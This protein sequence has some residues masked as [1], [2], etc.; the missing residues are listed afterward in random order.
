VQEDTIIVNQTITHSGFVGEQIL[1]TQPGTFLSCAGGSIGWAL[2]AAL[3]AKLAAK[4]RTV[5]SLMGDGAYVWGCPVATFWSAATYKAPFLSIIFNNQAYA[6]IK[7]IVQRAYGVEKLSAEIGREAGVDINPP[8]DYAAVARACGA[9]GLTVED[10]QDVL[11]S[12]RQAL[13]QVQSGRAAVLDVRVC[14]HL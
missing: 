2:G 13:A 5:V 10:P 7:G 9:F 1:R 12:L 14:G 6:A 11:P 8:P 4:D 3:G